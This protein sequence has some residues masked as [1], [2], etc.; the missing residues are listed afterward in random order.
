[1]KKYNFDEIVPREGTNCLKYDARE[2]FFKSKEVLPLWV[3]D[4]DFRTPDFIVEAIKKRVEHEIFG[5]TFRSDSYYE[6]IIGWMKR[7]HDWEIKREWISF[8]PGVVAGLTFAIE[9]FSKPGDGVVVQPPVYFPFF[10]SV[11]GTKRKM[12]ENPLKIENGRYTFDFEDLKSKIDENTKLLLLCNP[13]NPGG[14]VWSLEEL[15]E[16]C[17][18]CIENNIMIISDEIH[19][20]LI[21]KGHKHIPLPCISEEVA[22]NCVVTMA[23]SKTFNVA[24][25]SSSILIIPN[26]RKLIS[27]ERALG[28]GHLHMGNI[29]GTVAMEAAYTN[30]D[31]WLE[32]MLEYLWGNYQLLEDFI[33]TKLPKVKVMKPEATYL[34]WLDFTEY[35]MKNQ[36]LSAFATEKAKVGLNDGGRFGTGGDGW[37]R[38]NIGCPRSILIEALER[39]EK[40]FE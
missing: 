29:F 20:D 16:L 37:L 9:A 28:V 27:Y 2:M 11:K 32:Q 40:A 34:I 8:S 22:Q 21:Y 15:T 12:I 17:N 31:N 1:M 26:K 3:A 30:G 19:S 6:S 35:G 7:R 24:G 14:M 13:Q 18:I 10:D 33:N 36:E 25:F 39:L 4:M 5:Y 38:I 23:S